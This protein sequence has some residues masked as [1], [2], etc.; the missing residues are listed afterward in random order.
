MEFLTQ[1][2]TQAVMSAEE[3]QQSRWWTELQGHQVGP[4]IKVNHLMVSEGLWFTA[5]SSTRMLA[6]QFRAVGSVHPF[7]QRQL[8]ADKFIYKAQVLQELFERMEREKI[9]LPNS[10]VSREIKEIIENMAAAFP[11]RA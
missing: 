10:I 9:I 7:H 8:M 5:L 4:R 3:I 6:I 2:H 1:A 11:T